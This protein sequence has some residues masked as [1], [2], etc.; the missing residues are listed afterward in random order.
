M[1]DQPAIRAK[2]EALGVNARATPAADFGR[3]IDAETEKWRA[4]IQTAGI[5]L[6]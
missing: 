4:V 6:D 3:Q 5:T 1:L 2:L